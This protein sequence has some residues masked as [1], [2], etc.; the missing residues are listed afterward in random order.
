MRMKHKQNGSR[1]NKGFFLLLSIIVV[2]SVLGA[3]VFSTV[4]K[5]SQEMSSSAIH[6]LSESLDLLKGTIEAILIKESE[7]QGLLAQEIASM[8]RPEEFISSYNDNRTMVKV[9]IIL[10]GKAV[11]ISNTGEAFTEEGLDFSSG[12]TVEGLPLS[13][14]YLNDLGTWAYTMKCPVMRGGQEIASLYVEYIFDS[15]EEALPDGFYN[16][17][18]ML[19]IMDA[20]S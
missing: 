12:A 7:F 9:S 14:S 13:R 20:K 19:Y 2:F 11:G 17:K 4:R 6:N 8:E 1:N 3:V 18:A 15:F 16:G 10:A 5:I